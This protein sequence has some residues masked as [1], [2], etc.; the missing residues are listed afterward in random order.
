V[1]VRRPAILA[2]I[3]MTTV[4]VLPWASAG[5]AAAAASWASRSQMS[6]ATLTAAEATVANPSGIGPDGA[7]DAFR[8]HTSTKFS[9]SLMNFPDAQEFSRN[10]SWTDPQ[11]ATPAAILLD[12]FATPKEAKTAWA[13]MTGQIT[14]AKTAVTRENGLFT[15]VWT[16][17]SVDASVP[18]S[19]RVTQSR[20]QGRLLVLG[21]CLG[22]DEAA[23]TACASGVLNA[24]LVKSKSLA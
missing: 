12:Q 19:F 1:L 14:G 18:T 5:P 24:E 20:T 6:A 15:M 2:T 8:P 11:A 13:S 7:K 17:P 21:V 10:F 3:V 23:T 16:L 9:G 4:A 22:H